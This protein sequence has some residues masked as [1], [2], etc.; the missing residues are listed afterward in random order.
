MAKN[1]AEVKVE[2]AE[3]FQVTL[4]KE[5]STIVIDAGNVKDLVTLINLASLVVEELSQLDNFGKGQR[6]VERIIVN[7][8]ELNV[9][10]VFS[11][12]KGKES[13]YIFVNSKSKNQMI[14]SLLGG[15]F[16]FLF[17]LHKTF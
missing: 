4:R 7:G 8:C 17:L 1:A 11:P 2:L 12:E 6:G 9:T 3:G 16:L 5:G 14:N 10:A 13:F 15:F